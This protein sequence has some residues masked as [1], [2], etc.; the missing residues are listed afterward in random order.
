M[1]DYV[2]RSWDELSPLE[3]AQSEYSDYYKSVHGFRPR[4]TADWTLEDF[5]RAFEAL[6]EDAKREAEWQKERMERGVKEFEAALATTMEVCGCD[7]DTAWRY[8][9]DAE[10][11]DWYD[12]GYFEY[13]NDLPRGY[14]VDQGL[15]VVPP[16]GFFDEEEE[17][18]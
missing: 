3:Q 13:N 18:A 7:R 1:S 14:L 2:F 9:K 10:G 11:D 16:L 4:F 15:E 8:M 5:D 6:A 12:D 17:A